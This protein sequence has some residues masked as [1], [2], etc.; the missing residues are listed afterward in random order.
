MADV[1]IPSSTCRVDGCT[2]TI[3]ARDWCRKHYDRWRK[4]GSP[5]IRNRPKPKKKCTVTG[6]HG[7]LK[8]R[9][10]CIKHY[11]RWRNHGDPNV[12]KRRSRFDGTCAV[13]GQAGPFFKGGTT[14]IPCTYAKARVHAQTNQE[15]V[16]A[17]NRR[18]SARKRKNLR[19]EVINAYGGKCAC[20][21]E[22]NLVFLA[23]DHVEGGGSQHRR[24]LPGYQVYRQVRRDGFPPG[25]QVLCH[26]CNWAKY[27]GGCPHLTE[28]AG[29]QEGSCSPSWT[30]PRGP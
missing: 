7:T 17:R 6:C 2:R 25:F 19:L 4:N 23:L 13:C 1:R 20:C 24:R 8:A 11:T 27:R 15:K 29:A 26:N 21:G 16:R 14:C 10:Y 28:K 18:Y 22:T 3:L 12:V 9:G 30:P 5:L